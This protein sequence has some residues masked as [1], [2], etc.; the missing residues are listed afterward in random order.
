MKT[1]FTKYFIP[2][3]FVLL[4]G[5]SSL[6]HSTKGTFAKDIKHQ[7]YDVIIV[8]GYPYEGENWNTVIKMRVTWAKFLFDKGYTKNIIFSGGAVYSPYI[9]SRIFKAYAIAKGVP[10]ENIFTEEIAEHSVEN[11][12]YSYRIA[13]DKGFKKIA[14]STDAFQTNNTRRFIKKYDLDI[15]LL[16]V[17]IDTIVRLDRSEPKIDPSVAKTTNFVSIKER[18]GLCERLSGTFGKHIL[19]VEE[20]LK[21]KRF[22]KKLKNQ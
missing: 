13:K 11:I 10:E 6:F 4:S 17:I 18:E 19:W 8:P 7:P 22:K 9:E 21:K 14:L 16:P 2:V 15:K 5:C 12:Y 3:I 20:D 1:K